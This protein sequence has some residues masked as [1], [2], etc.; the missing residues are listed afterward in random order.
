MNK[1]IKNFRVEF[2]GSTCEVVPYSINIENDIGNGIPKIIIEG[3]ISKIIDATVWNDDGTV[4]KRIKKKK[5]KK[6][7][8]KKIDFGRWNNEDNN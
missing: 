1:N 7:S 5:A 4:N 3:H 2:N 6:K 8:S